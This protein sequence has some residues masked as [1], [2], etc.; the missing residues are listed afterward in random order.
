MTSCSHRV[1]QRLLSP[2]CDWSTSGN[3]TKSC[4]CLTCAVQI[5]QNLVQK[6]VRFGNSRERPHV[7]FCAN[8]KVSRNRIS[9]QQSWDNRSGREAS[10]SGQTC[11]S[12]LRELSPLPSASRAL[13]HQGDAHKKPRSSS[14]LAVT[15]FHFAVGLLL[16]WPEKKQKGIIFKR[17]CGDVHRC[18]VDTLNYGYRR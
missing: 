3:A 1:P 16:L 5:Y 18:G 2:C 11:D 6:Y 9:R 7:L 10:T 14:P 17:G 15:G 12:G 4:A 13:S 8:L